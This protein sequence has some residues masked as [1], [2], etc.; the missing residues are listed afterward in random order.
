MVR[1][2]PPLEPN[3]FSFMEKSVKNQVKYLMDLNP[4][5]RNARSTPEYFKLQ[6]VFAKSFFSCRTVVMQTASFCWTK[7]NFVGQYTTISYLPV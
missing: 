1:L 6:T 5:S 4:P 3:Y 2:N 7:P